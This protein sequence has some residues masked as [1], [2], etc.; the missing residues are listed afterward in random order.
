MEVPQKVP[1]YF[2]VTQRKPHF[3]LVPTNKPAQLSGYQSAP[4][5]TPVQLSPLVQD[6]VAWMLLTGSVIRNEGMTSVK[7]DVTEA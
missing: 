5:E 2:R 4:L 1:H 3:L 7:H 6:Q